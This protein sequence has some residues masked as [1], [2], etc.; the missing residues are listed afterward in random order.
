VNVIDG[1]YI[2]GGWQRSAGGES[3]TVI[4]PYTEEPIGRAAVGAAATISCLRSRPGGG[5]WGSRSGA[6]SAMILTA[7]ATAGSRLTMPARPTFSPLSVAS[8]AGSNHH[9]FRMIV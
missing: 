7:G 2:D 9:S 1:V 5:T 6:A 8:A 3:I 4:N